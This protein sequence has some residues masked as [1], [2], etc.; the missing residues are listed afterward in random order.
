MKPDTIMKLLLIAAFAAALASCIAPP[1][2][3]TYRPDVA[4]QLDHLAHDRSVSPI[5]GMG[6]SVWEIHGY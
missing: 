1:P 6:A 3:T 2:P 5:P 4:R